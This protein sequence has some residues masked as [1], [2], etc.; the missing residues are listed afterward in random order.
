MENVF[1][2]VMQF[3]NGTDQSIFLSGRAGTGKTTFLK[4]IRDNTFKKMIVVAPT[5]VA[6]VNAGGITIHSLL[7]LPMM[8]FVPGETFALDMIRFNKEKTILLEQ[9]EL[10]VIDEI[11]MVRADVLDAV[12][13]VLKRVRKK[14]NVPFGGVQLLLIGDL[15]QLSPVVTD[16]DWA[17]LSAIYSSPF[18]LDSH[19]YNQLNSLFFELTKVYRQNDDVFINILNSIRQNTCNENEIALLNSRVAPDVIDLS[20]VVTLT[21]HKSIAKLRNEESLESLTSDLYCFDALVTGDFDKSMFPA[22]EKLCLKTGA[23]VMLIKNLNAENFN[24]KIGKVIKIETDR[25]VINFDNGDVLSVERESWNNISFNYDSKADNIKEEVLGSFQQFPI[26]LAW[27]I[28]IHKSQGLTF[29]KALIDTAEAF[30]PGQVYVALSRVKSLEGLLLKTKISETSIFVHP[31]LVKFSKEINYPA[32]LPE[33]FEV[34][35]NQFIKRILIGYFDW[36]KPK[37]II[38]YQ[39]GDNL[40]VLN[41]LKISIASL[42]DVA[43]K[44]SLQ[45]ENILEKQNNKEYLS[46]RLLSAS[47]Y[48]LNE[49]KN[50]IT[51][52]KSFL[53]ESANDVYLKRSF[54]EIRLAIKFLEDKSKLLALVKVIGQELNND[55]KFHDILHREITF[56]KDSKVI[57]QS[58]LDINNHKTEQ[59]SLSLFRTGKSI[60]DIAIERK[61]TTSTVENHLASF[62]KEGKILI[63][64]IIDDISLSSILNVLKNNDGA[65]LSQIKVLVDDSISLGQINAV[66]TYWRMTR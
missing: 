12:D 23:L 1:S 6:A 55:V 18:F 27:A 45:L 15:Y 65:S 26:R 13:Y 56:S 8:P 39:G 57:V 61:L 38:S 19:S 35:N 11:S 63:G 7:S 62:L 25:I 43:E 30:A 48:F 29:E 14:L 49:I 41:S 40:Q 21:T 58:T 53:K 28:T 54:P 22:D 31:R 36:G 2:N 9:L 64:D 66:L 10:L 16:V 34:L 3:I 42:F 52:L 32:N 59:I 47:E 20:N 60:E 5:G 37:N 44:F 24:G 17:K 50:I 33:L 4:Q 51:D 46:A